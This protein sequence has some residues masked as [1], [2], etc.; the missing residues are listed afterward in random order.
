MEKVG[1][2]EVPLQAEVLF[3]IDSVQDRKSP[4]FS[5][6]VAPE[7]STTFHWKVRYPGIYGQ[8]NLDLM[9]LRKKRRGHEAECCLGYFSTA[10]LRL[11]YILSATRGRER[12]KDG[13]DV[14]FWNSKPIISEKPFPKTTPLNPLQTVPPTEEQA[15][16]YMI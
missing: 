3:T 11:Y 9:G 1:E 8:F 16:K 5:K 6:G 13:N 12:E 7:G 14:G 4:F 15:F 2:Q 10:M